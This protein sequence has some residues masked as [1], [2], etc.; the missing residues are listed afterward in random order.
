MEVEMTGSRIEDYGD[1]KGK[2]KANFKISG[3]MVDADEMKAG[4]V[5]KKNPEMMESKKDMETKMETKK[6]KFP[7]GMMSK[8]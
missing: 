6:E 8:K 5:V 4:G 2:L 3:I 7:S 1:D